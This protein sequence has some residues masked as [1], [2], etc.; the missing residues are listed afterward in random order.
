MS[1]I[2]KALRRLEEDRNAGPGRPLRAA[3]TS[4]GDGE[5]KRRG[6]WLL[7]SALG[8]GVGLA[9][10][11]GAYW[12]VS[13]QGSSEPGAPVA[14]AP[15]SEPLRRVAV[16]PEPEPLRRVAVAPDPEP[17]PRVAVAPDPELAGVVP[18]EAA[19]TPSVSET[20]V[21][22]APTAVIAAEPPMRRQSLSP[23]ALTSPVER[24]ERPM[25]EPRIAADDQDEEPLMLGS[26]N[27]RRPRSELGRERPS[28][29]T[30]AATSR[31]LQP[32][33]PAAPSEVDPWEQAVVGDASKRDEVLPLVA[34]APD[35]ASLSREM[36][37]PKPVVQREPAVMPAADPQ[38]TPSVVTESKPVAAAK[39]ESAPKAE[40]TPAPSGTTTVSRAAVPGVRVE[41]IF[42]HPSA[43]RRTALIEVNGGVEEIHEGDAVGPL[44]V[45]TIEPSGVV[46][47]HDGIEIRR[48]VGE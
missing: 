27:R 33:R 31:N 47:Q 41:K 40:K 21:P 15:H 8:L 29:R 37:T 16:A 30:S 26:A 35:A 2:L 45:S 13:Q 28:S 19:P 14:V 39:R 9:A 42:W 17:L 43:E 23:A 36:P 22:G 10:S 32:A 48:R 12:F 24:V 7:A 44:V 1:T 18:G 3:V 38:S 5:R 4:G 46:F 25:P 34:V 6:G 11:G 20:P